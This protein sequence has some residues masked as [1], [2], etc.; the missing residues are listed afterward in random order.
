MTDL[1]INDLPEEIIVNTKQSN[2]KLQDTGQRFES[3]EHSDIGNYSLH[4]FIDWLS[5]QP[6]GAKFKQQLE[7]FL[8][9]SD[10][11]NE[12][13]IWD[14][15]KEKSTNEIP[16][17]EVQLSTG[18]RITVGEIVALAGDFFGIAD[19]PIS[20]ADPEDE[21]GSTDRFE[22]AY[23]TPFSDDPEIGNIISNVV[24]HVRAEAE[25]QHSHFELGVR[26]RKLPMQGLLGNIQYGLERREE[27]SFKGF[28]HSP[29]FDL[30]LKNFDHFGQEARRTFLTGHKIA[31]KK[32]Q[33]AGSQHNL[34]ALKIAF[35]QEM[36]A[37]H[38]LTDLFASGHIR[39]PRKEILNYIIKSR[40]KELSN[41][42]ISQNPILKDI[43]SIDILMAGL[44]GKV[45]HDQDS[46]NGVYVKIRKN[47][48]TNQERNPEEIW[49]ASGDGNF[50]NTSNQAYAVIVC[51]TV[52]LALKDLYQAYNNN[53]DFTVLDKELESYIPEED[54]E[55]N[56]RACNRPLFS[57]EGNTILYSG[58]QRE[59]DCVY[60]N[61]ASICCSLFDITVKPLVHTVDEI[62][63][64]TKEKIEALHNRLMENQASCRLQ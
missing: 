17:Y 34:G 51:Q 24:N 50:Y 40:N 21:K 38:F 37:C 35:L 39:T 7:S 64:D 54:H 32:A 33:E 15:V 63:T 48:D 5:T 4:C 43:S 14:P 30:A 9:I 58:M 28:W 25:E 42:D 41:L 29:Y 46:S 55:Q 11:P 8:K 20:F 16:I 13:Q 45:M 53:L 12:I 62:K 6:E 47:A 27:G 49:L 57:K 26:C 10:N 56:L 3:S 60:A 23:M 18:L 31:I 22:D 52:V 59:L 36:F 44:V 2:K 1:K 19:R 61:V